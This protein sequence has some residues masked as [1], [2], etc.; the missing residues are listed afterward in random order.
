MLF[1]PRKEWDRIASEQTNGAPFLYLGVLIVLANLLELVILVATGKKLP[2][3]SSIAQ[4]GLLLV[5]LAFVFYGFSLLW[6]SI[7]NALAP[8][9]GARKRFTSAFSLIAYGMTPYILTGL[10][11]F[12][13]FLRPITLVIALYS[14]VL[15]WIG[16]PRVMGNPMRT[17]PAFFIVAIIMTLIMYFVMFLGVGF[18]LVLKRF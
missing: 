6:A 5:L 7:I 14:L 3:T 10:L 13:Q 16:M 12:D 15:I 11:A 8:F 18:F 17:R 2:G 9:F 4:G 1:S